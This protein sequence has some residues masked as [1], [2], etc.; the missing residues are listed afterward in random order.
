MDP[1]DFPDYEPTY[2]DLGIDPDNPNGDYYSSD[3]DHSG[4]DDSANGSDYVETESDNEDDY[5]SDH[6]RTEPLDLRSQV[7]CLYSPILGVTDCLHSATSLIGT[8]SLG[9]T[10]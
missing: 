6:L 1:M 9:R 8:T 2:A 4:P 10:P 5:D 3:E 7:C